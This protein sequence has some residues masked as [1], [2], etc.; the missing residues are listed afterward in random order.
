[1]TQNI[2][3]EVCIDS[4]ESALNAI[5]GGANRLELCGNVGLGGGTTPSFGLVRIIQ[6]AVESFQVPIMVMIRPRTGDFLY[7]ESEMQ[8]MLEDIRIFKEMAGVEGFVFGVLTKEGRVDVTRT[9]RLIDASL[10]ARVC[11]HRAFDMTRDPMEALNDI[12]EID[13][14]TRILSSGQYKSASQTESLETLASLLIAT[15]NSNLTIMPGSGINPYTVRHVVNTLAPL[16]LSEIHLSGGRW[17]EGGMIFRREGMG[18]GI[19]AEG[20]W[21]IWQTDEGVIREVRALLESM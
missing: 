20:D 14:V 10:P 17:I 7:S 1:M 13:G 12:K 8:V 21:G 9:R 19:G 5:R 3:M 11:F 6:R 18:M 15:R 4:V 2:L 16:G